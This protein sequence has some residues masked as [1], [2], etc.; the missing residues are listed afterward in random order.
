[1]KRAGSSTTD[2]SE[3]SRR[4]DGYGDIGDMMATVRYYSDCTVP[5]LSYYKIPPI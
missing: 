4:S 3:Q 5:K 1:M 2:D